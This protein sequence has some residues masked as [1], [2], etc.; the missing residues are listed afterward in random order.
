MNRSIEKRG[1]RTRLILTFLVYSTV[2]RLQGKTCQPLLTSIELFCETRRSKTYDKI[3]RQ[4]EH[5]CTITQ[6]VSKTPRRG[7]CSGRSGNVAL[8]SKTRLGN[9]STGA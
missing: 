8:H 2:Y 1:S 3:I 5:D 7:I 9:C 4:S 6:S